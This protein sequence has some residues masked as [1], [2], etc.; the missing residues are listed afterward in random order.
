MATQIRFFGY[1][2][3]EVVT[4]KGLRIIIDPYLDAS[5]VSPV[6][7]ADLDRVVL[8]LVTHGAWDHIGDS[9]KIALRCGCPVIC[10]PEV[11]EALVSQGVPAEQ[12]LSVAWGLGVDFRGLRLRPVESHHTSKA[13]LADG[14]WAAGFPTGF[15]IYADEQT[16]IYH[17][18][19]TA[20]FGDL[21]LIG[22]VYRPNVA[23][24]HVSLPDSAKAGDARVVTGEMTPYEAALACQ[25][26]QAEY[27]IPCHFLDPDC[28]DVRAFVGL[29]ETMAVDGKPKTKPIVLRPGEWWTRND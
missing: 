15:V 7:S 16:R 5:E 21:R 17:M 8:V 29:L 18:G 14:R 3:F 13:L 6:R 26:L 27:A 1:A 4:S 22:E 2:S 10:G 11:K 28:D 23:L 20:L 24:V 9:A 19:D 12:V 25:W